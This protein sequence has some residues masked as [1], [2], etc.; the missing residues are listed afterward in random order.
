MF[1]NTRLL[2]C[3]FEIPETCHLR[4]LLLLDNYTAD[5]GG[6]DSDYEEP[7]A[8]PTEGGDVEGQYESSEV[9]DNVATFSRLQ[10]D[11]PVLL[12]AASVPLPDEEGDVDL[13]EVKEVADGTTEEVTEGAVSGDVAPSAS[14]VESIFQLPGMRFT[15]GPAYSR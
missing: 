11:D 14:N 7:G 8:P 15:S 6:A 5:G 9:G 13:G 1:L 2:Y 4:D 12:L 10:D 3:P